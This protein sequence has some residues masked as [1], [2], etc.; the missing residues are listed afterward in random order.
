MIDLFKEELEIEK[1]NF[2]KYQGALKNGTGKLKQKSYLKK[3]FK[4]QTILNT[5]NN[6]RIIFHQITQLIVSSTGQEILRKIFS[7]KFGIKN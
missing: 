7:K 5:R 6:L 2:L 3:K 1:E 4:K